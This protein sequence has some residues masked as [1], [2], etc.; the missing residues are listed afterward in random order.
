VTN[1]CTAIEYRTRTDKVTLQWSVARSVA[2]RRKPQGKGGW[3]GDTAGKSGRVCLAGA[4]APAGGRQ[5]RTDLTRV[6]S[7]KK[8]NGFTKT[9]AAAQYLFRKRTRYN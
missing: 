3:A 1:R 8:S 2:R 6:K 7:V 9:G 5:A 4:N